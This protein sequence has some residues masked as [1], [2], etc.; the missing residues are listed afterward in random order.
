MTKTKPKLGQLIAGAGGVLLIVS[1][2][3]PWASAGETDQTGFELLTM[4]DVFLLIVGLIAI[5]AALT[6][7]RFGLFRADVSVNGAADLLGVV[8]TI[9]VAYF[10][11]DF[12]PG[13]SR[14][15]GVFLALVAT[16]AIAGGAGDYSTLRGAPLFP[17]VDAD[18]RQAS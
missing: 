18:E 13:A 11:F 8:A 5:G 17:R 7:G 14:E 2:F 16:I 1:L 15:I 4:A 10:L 9:V 12:P 3:L 6:W